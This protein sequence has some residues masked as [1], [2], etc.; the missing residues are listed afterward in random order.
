M[1][2]HDDSPDI[3]NNDGDKEHEQQIGHMNKTAQP[4]GDHIL[5]RKLCV[6]IYE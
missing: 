6:C 1:M 2:V 5:K 3:D 4:P